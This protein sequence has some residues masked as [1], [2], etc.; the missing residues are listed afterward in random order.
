MSLN[1]KIWIYGNVN[2]N[3]VLELCSKTRGFAQGLQCCSPLAK[4]RSYM[5]IKV[6]NNY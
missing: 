1:L 6:K 5:R 4:L 2:I 3:Y